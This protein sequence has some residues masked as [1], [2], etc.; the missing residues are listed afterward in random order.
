MFNVFELDPLAGYAFARNYGPIFHRQYQI[1]EEHKSHGS[2]QCI[3]I[4]KYVVQK[5]KKK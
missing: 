4:S 3:L 1:N 5:N 2:R